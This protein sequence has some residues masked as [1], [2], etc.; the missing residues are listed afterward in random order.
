MSF[1]KDVEFLVKVRDAHQMLADAY[2]DF[3]ESK[4]PIKNKDPHKYD[5][6]FWERKQGG[7]GEFEQTSSKAKD[8]L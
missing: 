1:T 2:N 7:K 5:G 4:S 6:L 8:S 3:I